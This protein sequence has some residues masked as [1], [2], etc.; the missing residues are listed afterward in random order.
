MTLPVVPAAQTE[1]QH[2]EVA[3]QNNKTTFMHKNVKMTTSKKLISRKGVYILKGA[4]GFCWHCQGG[5]ITSSQ[6]ACQV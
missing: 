3:L 2:F 4:M 1:F 5:R 6:G